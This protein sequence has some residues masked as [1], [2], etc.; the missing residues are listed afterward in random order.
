MVGSYPKPHYLFPDSG[1]SLLDSVGASFWKMRTK[2]GSKKH[3]RRLNRAVRLAIRDQVQAGVDMISDG[4]EQ[5]DHYIMYVLR[6]LAGIDFEHL[7]EIT[8]REGKY[9]RMVPVIV[10]R[11]TYRQAIT[12]E[13]FRFARSYARKM[14]K[15]NLPGPATIADTIADHFYQGD[16]ERI[17]R[18]YALVIKKE[19]GNLIKAGCRA[20]QFD[21]PVLMRNLEAA[22]QWGIDV[23]ESCV[24][25]YKLEAQFFLHI[26]RGY[27]D[28]AAEKEGT[29]YKAPQEN[30][31]ELLDLLQETSFDVVSIEGAQGNLDLSALAHSGRKK[32]MLGVL[33]VGTNQVEPV[34]DLAAR[35]RE[36]LNYLPPE[37]LILSPDCGMIE[38]NR[39]SAKQKLKNL[40]L[41]VKLL[42]REIDRPMGR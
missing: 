41:A 40:A 18:A 13:D 11:L 15:V 32:I 12:V 24:A 7:E 28:P 2:I 8:F 9:K 21:D 17:A 20:I 16:R 25:D 27:P 5:R 36:A 31:A 34:G 33:D 6:G 30:Y 3:R 39:H 22:G 29:L 4:E 35:G 42:N 37:Q 26:C 1:R 14:V 10:D 38:L 19:V 23:L